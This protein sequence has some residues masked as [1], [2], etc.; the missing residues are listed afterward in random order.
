SGSKEGDKMVSLS[1]RIY[2]KLLA[3]YPKRF[4]ELYGDEM[5][6]LFEDECREQLESGGKSK[7]F[8]VWICAVAD[9]VA[10]VVLERGRFTMG[11]SVVRWGGFL[12]VAGGSLLAISGI[13]MS[14]LLSRQTWSYAWNVATVGQMVGMLLLTLSLASL[15]ALLASHGDS[16]VSLARREHLGN[17]RRFTRMQWSAMVGVV[18][19]AVAALA[20]AGLLTMFIMFELVGIGDSSRLYP[21]DLENFLYPT[22]GVLVTFGLPLALTLLGLAVWR[23]RTMGHWSIL[24]LGVGIVT[25]LIP[26]ATITVAHVLW[27]GVLSSTSF[28]PVILIVAIPAAAIG[29][30]W[31]LLGLALVRIENADQTLEARVDG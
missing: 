13:L 11:S 25:F 7:L 31:A 10:N 28:L 16:R 2:E 24:P 22:L 30:M 12:A 14:W 1:R 5:V 15:V 19:I 18:S 3:A 9:L 29:T 20:A 17:I 26:L 27:G 23:S 6:D 8:V 21:S 4:R